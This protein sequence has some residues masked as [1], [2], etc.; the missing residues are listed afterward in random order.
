[1]KFK[2]GDNVVV[3]TGKDK[4]KLG[5]IAKIFHKTQKILIEGVNVVKKHVKPR[6]DF[7]GGIVEL[8]K[9]IDASNAMMVCPHTKK[10]TRIGYKKEDGQKK[11]YSKKSG[12]FLDDV[13]P[14]SVKQ[15]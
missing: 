4:G 10:R 1:M 3:V 2:T 13:A 14:V 5:V 7:E 9:P 12:K 6:G 8:E 15:K 11:R